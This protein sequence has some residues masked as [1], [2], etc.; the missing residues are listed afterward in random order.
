MVHHTEK[1]P[2]AG[3]M[4]VHACDHPSKAG[5]VSTL[6]TY[7]RRLLLR[8]KVA[9][10]L[11]AGT[12]ESVQRYY[13]SRKSECHFLLDPSHYEYPRIGWM[14]EEIRDG[15][16]LE[17]G[18]ADG[19]MTRLL[20]PRVGRVVALDLCRESLQS[21]E[22]LGLANV[23]TCCEF[24]ERYV[25]PAPFDWMVMSEVVEHLRKPEQVLQRCV[26]WLRQGGKLLLSTPLGHW[27][28]I[29]HLQEFDMASWCTLLGASGARSISAFT[30][31]D[32]EGRDR[33]L[34]A[35]LEQ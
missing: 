5:M 17:V 26:G 32:H 3:D 30:I 18:A 10:D 27:D 2:L 34:G 35:R 1:E 9:G 28:S 21:I 14:L 25:P 7:V 20:A 31:P 13:N 6:K 33:W 16:V 23:E 19:G 29:E 22:E 4:S 8:K 24:V 12:D 11:L 15:V